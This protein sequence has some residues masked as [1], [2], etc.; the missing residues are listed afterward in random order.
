MALIKSKETR[1]VE[2]LKKVENE[3]ERQ[4]RRRRNI[5]HFMFAG[6]AVLA[7]AAFIGGH[8][9]GKYCAKRRR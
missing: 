7:V 1:E 4:E 6:L 8:A 2:L 5:R 3:I 9:S